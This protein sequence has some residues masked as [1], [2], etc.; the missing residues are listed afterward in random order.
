[1]GLTATWDPLPLDADAARAYVRVFAAA[2]SAGQYWLAPVRESADRRYGALANEVP[3]YTRDTKD[4]SGLED[5]L[6]VEVI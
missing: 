4:F 1:M 6:R 5:V 2:R 3:L